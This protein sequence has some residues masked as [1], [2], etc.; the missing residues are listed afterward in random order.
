MN[1]RL[2]KG[3]GYELTVFGH[4][5]MHG[6]DV[7]LPTVDDQAIDGVLRYRRNSDGQIYYLDIQVKGAKNI[8]G[9]NIVVDKLPDKVLLLLYDAVEEKIYWFLRSDVD[10]FF[11]SKGCSIS[12]VNWNKQLIQD[13]ERAGHS[14]LSKLATILDIAS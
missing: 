14:D 3:K 8:R 2:R 13:I 12:D 4:L 6:F 1:L 5:T 11:P 7:Y 9:T 10:G